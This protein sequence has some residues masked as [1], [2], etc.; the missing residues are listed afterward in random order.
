MKI[1][2]FIDN[3]S[4]IEYKKLTNS[5]TN[6]DEPIIKKQLNYN[7]KNIIKNINIKPNKNTSITKLTPRIK[8]PTRL[9]IN[10]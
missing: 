9:N 4:N 2:K 5:I 6:E 10:S 1:N 3:Y 8:S 7:T